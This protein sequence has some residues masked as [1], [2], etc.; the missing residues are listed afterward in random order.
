MSFE[1]Q[2]E[3]PS[4]G[5]TGAADV[6]APSYVSSSRTLTTRL[7]HVTAPSLRRN[8]TI[9]CSVVEMVVVVVVVV[10]AAVVVVVVVACET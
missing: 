9:T 10:A 5:F 2:L 3:T 1:I 4:R 6:T 7:F 8:R